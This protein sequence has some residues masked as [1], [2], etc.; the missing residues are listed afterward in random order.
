MSDTLLETSKVPEKTTERTI[1][2]YLLSLTPSVNFT[3]LIGLLIGFFH[4]FDGIHFYKDCSCPDDTKGSCIKFQKT[5]KACKSKKCLLFSI[6]LI[7]LTFYVLIS[8]FPPIS[9]QIKNLMNSKY[10]KLYQ[11]LL[12]SPLLA[13]LGISIYLMVE[14]KKEEDKKE[15]YL[16]KEGISGSSSQGGGG[17]SAGVILLIIGILLLIG[18]IKSPT[19]CVLLLITS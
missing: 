7:I 9:R 1:S 11:F 12:L 8:Q 4:L 17:G 14:E 16:S 3:A 5:G 6:S 2:E 19:F 13:V 15:K 10:K 18:C